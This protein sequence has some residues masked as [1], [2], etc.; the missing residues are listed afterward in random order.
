MTT[1]GF[2]IRA[3]GFHRHGTVLLDDLRLELR[4]RTR[5]A[6]IGPSGAGKSTLLRLLAGLDAPTHGQILLDDVV[7]SQPQRIIVPPH[8]R[9]VSMLFQDLALWPNLPALGN[10]MLALSGTRL[11][12]EAR[13]KRAI[14]V[15]DMIGIGHLAYRLPD[16]LS[17]GEQQRVALARALAPAPRYLFLDE[18]FA[19][20]DLAVKTRLLAEI[21]QCAE[22]ENIAIVLV[23]HDPLEAL[24]LGEDG[25]VLEHGRL[26][27]HGLLRTLLATAAPQSETLRAFR[28]QLG[29]LNQPG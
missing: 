7:I 3:V 24:G 21:A 10:V 23:T 20:I 2:E 9:T 18:P 11:P 4:P 8:Q 14:A 13:R 17:G 22:R 25:V 1:Q 15:L 12:T 5:T 26:I 29:A 28:A 27:E 6:I 16:T 19:S